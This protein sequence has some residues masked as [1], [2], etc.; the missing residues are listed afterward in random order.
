MPI[1][2]IAKKGESIESIAYRYGLF[3]ETLWDAPENRS[4]RKLRREPNILLPGDEV[5]VPDKREKMVAAQTAKRHVFR[6][7]GVPS[8]LRVRLLASG[9]P[10]AGLS[11]TVR[12]STGWTRQGT[13]DGDGWAECFLMPD[14]RRG[15]L[16]LDS[17]GETYSFSIGTVSPVDTARGV[18]AR[19]RNLG[20]FGG[21]VGDALDEEAVSALRAFQRSRSLAD[22]GQADE[23]TRS[24]LVEAHGS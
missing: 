1:R 23:A 9:K 5:F 16:R 10:R 15:E 4:L 19:L 7:R 18:L 24:A 14:A 20:F 22:S 3:W 6:R 21:E 8:V 17:T 13:T 2:H 12:V 11:F